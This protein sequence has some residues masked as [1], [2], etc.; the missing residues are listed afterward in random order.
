MTCKSFCDFSENRV[1]IIW[2]GRLAIS[3]TSIPAIR[4]DLETFLDRIRIFT[5]TRKMTSEPKNPICC[6]TLLPNF[7]VNYIHSV[8]INK[9]LF[10]IALGIWSYDYNIGYYKSE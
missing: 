4:K 10:P 1:D 6:F 2:K 3:R 7:D 9:L 8:N 5:I